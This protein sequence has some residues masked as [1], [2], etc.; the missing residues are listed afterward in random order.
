MIPEV[1]RQRFVVIGLERIGGALLRLRAEAPSA[2]PITQTIVAVPTT[3]GAL[4]AMHGEPFF[5]V[6][7]HLVT[8]TGQA[9]VGLAMTPTIYTI[10]SVEAVDQGLTGPGVDTLSRTGFADPPITK[11]ALQIAQVRTA[12]ILGVAILAIETCPIIAVAI[13]GAH[14]G[15][16]RSVADTASAGHVGADIGRRSAAL[17]VAIFVWRTIPC[18]RLRRASQSNDRACIRRTCS[19]DAN[20]FPKA[21]FITLTEHSV[22]T[23]TARRITDAGGANHIQAS[24]AG[25]LATT[26]HTQD[27]AQSNEE[28][29][30]YRKNMSDSPCS[31]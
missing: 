29:Q 27:Q 15:P 1:R 8:R 14:T 7:A 11:P 2:H 4:A 24:I 18:F 25:F 12:C 28:A 22:D 10:M 16:L 5:I 17:L 20:P 26:T 30:A 6:G 13:L 3:P 31:A 23:T 9:G 21:L 19:L